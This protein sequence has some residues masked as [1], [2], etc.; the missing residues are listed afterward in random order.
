MP[1]H[2]LRRIEQSVQFVRLLKVNFAINNS[3]VKID[4]TSSIKKAG[5]Q[6][7]FLFA[8]NIK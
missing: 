5:H 6:P 8:V 4:T 2:I 3:K 1:K 7:A